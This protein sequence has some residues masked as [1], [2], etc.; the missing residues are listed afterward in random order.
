MFCLIL[1]LI[2]TRGHYSIDIFGGLLFGHYFWIMSEKVAW[3]V[4]YLLFKIP[5]YQR[6]PYFPKSCFNC[7]NNINKWTNVTF[8]V[9]Y[10]ENGD[11]IDGSGG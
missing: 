9:C 11:P 8:E 3:I 10:D 2:F 6:S 7:K 5:F 1:L 4:D